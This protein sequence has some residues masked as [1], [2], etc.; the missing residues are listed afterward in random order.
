MVYIDGTHL[1]YKYSFTVYIHRQVYLYV[2]TEYQYYSVC[3]VYVYTLKVV[4]VYKHHTQE[5]FGGGNFWQTI[6]VKGIGE[7]KF[8]K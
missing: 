7:E 8:G 2:K 4:L 3:K 6:Q 5:N 1:H